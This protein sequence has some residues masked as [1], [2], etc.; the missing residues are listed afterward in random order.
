[1]RLHLAGEGL[2]VPT[3]GGRRRGIPVGDEEGAGQRRQQLGEGDG[4]GQGEAAAEGAEDA[5]EHGVGLVAGV[6]P[7]GI[8]QLLEQGLEQVG[9]AAVSIGTVMAVAPLLIAPHPDASL[10]EPQ[11]RAPIEAGAGGNDG[12]NNGLVEAAGGA[13]LDGGGAGGD[14]AVSRGDHGGGR[15]GARGGDGGGGRAARG[16]GAGCGG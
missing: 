2:A 15:G 11:L 14:P 16:P 9:G 13:A 8:G 6:E 12:G 4:L 1:Q 3:G 5:L 10:P 7:G